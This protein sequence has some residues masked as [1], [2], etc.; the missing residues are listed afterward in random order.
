MEIRKK[1]KDQKLASDVCKVE[2]REKK[3]GRLP[4]YFKS[5]N[6][7]EKAKPENYQVFITWHS[8]SQILIFS[9]LSAEKE[10]RTTATPL[11]NRRTRDIIMNYSS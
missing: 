5:E 9:K 6:R 1:L 7:A 2:F 10:A 3:G 11:K 8:T 4:R